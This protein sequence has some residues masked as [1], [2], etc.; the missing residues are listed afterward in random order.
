MM[1]LWHEMTILKLMLKSPRCSL[2]EKVDYFESY[3]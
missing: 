1:V 2:T 3:L